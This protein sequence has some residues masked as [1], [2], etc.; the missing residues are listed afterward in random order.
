M[1]YALGGMLRAHRR[2]ITLSAVNERGAR[3]PGASAIIPKGSLTRWDGC[4]F[5]P[6]R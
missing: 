2:N 4:S 6:Q 1:R 5:A 3:S